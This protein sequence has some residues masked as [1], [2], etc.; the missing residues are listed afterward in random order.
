M[1]ALSGMERNL[2]KEN[3]RLELIFVDDGS[4]DGSLQE[5]LKIKATR[6]ETKV[7][8]LTRNFGALH[9]YKAGLSQVTGDCFTA[10]SAD[11]Q[12]PPELILQMFIKWRTGSK[13]ILCHRQERQDPFTTRLF[14]R[15]Y[16]FLLRLF[17]ISDYPPGGF[18]LTLMDK[19]FLPFLCKSGKNIN[20]FLFSFWLG[21]K[22]EVIP[23][24]REHRKFGKSRWTFRKKFKLFLDSLLG[25]SVVPIRCISFV[26]LLVSIIS[27]LYGLFV[28]VNALFGNFAPVRGFATLAAL[29]AFLLG[30][31]IV[32]LGIIGEYIWRI[33]DQVNGRP[34]FV[35]E[36]IY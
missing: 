17:V 31:V 22:P 12:D 28:V 14:A 34:E 35:I 7:V 11:L 30:L 18:D 21:Y 13:Y 6:P 25:F 15:V 9:A 10:I 27:F 26:G 33:F 4:G 23:Y 8:K 29:L 36:E 3:G 1:S 24:K 16:Y 20:T 5:L 2:E 32:M 19:Q